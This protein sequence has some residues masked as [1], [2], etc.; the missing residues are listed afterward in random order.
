LV[1]DSESYGVLKLVLKSNQLDF[2]FLPVAGKF[3]DVG[4]IDCGH[5]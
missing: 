3:R 4:V 2:E 1:F 5:L